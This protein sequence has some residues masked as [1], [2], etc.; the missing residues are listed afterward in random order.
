MDWP[1]THDWPW[2]IR[3]AL[4]TGLAWPGLFSTLA[5]PGLPS[6]TVQFFFCTNFLAFGTYQI[7]SCDR[8]PK[9]FPPSRHDATEMNYSNK[10]LQEYLKTRRQKRVIYQSLEHGSNPVSPEVV[11]KIQP[12]ASGI[13]LFTPKKWYLDGARKFTDMTN[14]NNINKTS[15]MYIVTIFHYISYELGE[16]MVDS[17]EYPKQMNF[18][19]VCGDY[20]YRLSIMEQSS[21]KNIASLIHNLIAKNAEIA[22]K[23]REA[24]KPPHMD[25]TE[26]EAWQF[27]YGLTLSSWASLC[28]IYTGETIEMDQVYAT[29]LHDPRNPANPLTV[30]SLQRSCNLAKRY[31]CEESYGDIKCY[32]RELPLDEISGES[33]GMQWTFPFPENVYRMHPRYCVPGCVKKVYWPCVSSPSAATNQSHQKS[34]IVGHLPAPPKTPVFDERTM[35]QQQFEAMTANHV[36]EMEQ[37]H[38]D[39][40]PKVAE[41]KI[42]YENEIARSEEV[43][44]VA[45]T[46]ESLKLKHS[47]LISEL[48]APMENTPY[49]IAQAK[50]T[51]QHR[52]LI[53]FI[54]VF[55]ATEDAPDAI[56]AISRWMNQYTRQHPSFCLPIPKVTSNLTMFGDEMMLLAISMETLWD[57]N[58][59]H[60]DILALYLKDMHVYALTGF[61]SHTFMG[62]PKALGKSHIL[63]VEMDRMLIPGTFLNTTYMSAKANVAPGRKNQCMIRK[64]EDAPHSMVG[65]DHGSKGTET[66]HSDF[67]ALMKAWLTSGVLNA[68]VLDMSSAGGRLAAKSVDIQS[69][70]H[71]TVTI[72]TNASG[73]QLPDAMGS[74]FDVRTMQSR[75]RIEGD[76]LLGKA[77][78]EVNH[79]IQKASEMF[80]LR[81]QRNQAFFAIIFLLLYIDYFP[82]KL[83]LTVAKIIFRKSLQ[84]GKHMGLNG[85]SEVR[86]FERLCFVC[87]VVVIWEAITLVWDSPESNVE[88]MPHDITHFHIVER[89]LRSNVE[90]A[91]FVMGLMSSQYEDS[92]SYSIISDLMN[93]RFRKFLND[94]QTPDHITADLDFGISESPPPAPVNLWR[95][96]TL[97]EF[98]VQ[99]QQQQQQQMQQ[100]QQQ[101]QQQPPKLVATSNANY[102]GVPFRSLPGARLDTRGKIVALVEQQY[103]TM[104][105]K[106]LK[107]DLIAA[108]EALTKRMVNDATRYVAPDSSSSS[109]SSCS[110]EEEKRQIPALDFSSDG[111]MWL[112]REVV[113]NNRL[114]PLLQ[115]VSRVIDHQHANPCEYIYGITRPY[116][117][118]LF[119]TIKTGMGDRSTC[120][121]LEFTDP[122]FYHPTLVQYTDIFL[123]GTSSVLHQQ[124]PVPERT[125]KRQKRQSASDSKEEA[126]QQEEEEEKE[127]EGGG[128]VLLLSSAYPA[129]A[130]HVVDMDLNEMAEFKFLGEN[131][132]Q[133]TGQDCLANGDPCIR[134]AQLV[135]KAEMEGRQLLVY[136][137]DLPHSKPHAYLQQQKQH[138]VNHPEEYSMRA[139]LKRLADANDMRYAEKGP[140]A[141]GAVPLPPVPEE[142]EEEEDRE[143]D[144]EEEEEEEDRT[145]DADGELDHGL[146]T[147]HMDTQYDPVQ[148]DDDGST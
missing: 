86:N 95:Q 53:D 12:S 97:D 122:N 18:F 73:R 7:P 41:L 44:E 8:S 5:W 113:K 98:S 101:E 119:Q 112:S 59:S 9:K 92:I 136:P 72:V 22:S 15:M 37:Y 19:E 135:S 30:F 81:F 145:H 62:G 126:M 70:C 83:D 80:S 100:Q 117:P 128:G 79:L 52:T 147:M 49:N 132:F 103:K 89:F 106:P 20:G 96:A 69:L 82:S 94:G 40:E 148:D 78:R 134:K 107:E 76:G 21:S 130:Y 140:A 43:E 67:E 120:P 99:R 36:R 4:W 1:G 60:S 109:S 91:T 42:L 141:V 121:L 74:R 63:K 68:N 110:E 118:F 139:Y 93:T 35:T 71:S 116:M 115:C 13:W 26:E 16:G 17:C 50:K 28:R 105:N 142:E 29:P 54:N 46:F 131:Y 66:G 34:F 125:N 65:I 55:N 51:A 143:R 137:D 3:L 87:A 23:Q 77:G 85:V 38:R 111:M 108:Y 32:N 90:H 6:A 2:D 123:S 45:E 24:R 124:D 114:N 129:K 102:F 104:S 39:N 11:S 57:I 146:S 31:G 84:E 127:P 56:R 48:L 64:F 61:N 88:G 138:R 25:E 144:E 133:M 47:T 27:L 14:L 10:V 33:P 58:V 75:D